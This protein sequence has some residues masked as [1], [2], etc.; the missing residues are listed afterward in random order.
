[1]KQ[2]LSYKIMGSPE[3]D[4]LMFLHGFGTASWGWWQQVEALEE[5]YALLLVDLPGHGES[6]HITWENMEKTVDLVADLIPHGK[7]V[8]LIG[9]SL[10]GHVALELAK[11]YPENIHSTYISG[12]TT[13]P[14]GPKFFKGLLPLYLRQIENLQS[15]ETK[16][17]KLFVQMGMPQEKIAA[18]ISEYQKVSL[19]SV[20]A[21]FN[22]LYSF[23][24]DESYS[25]ISAP[26]M[27]VACEYEERGIQQ[28]LTYA[29]TIIE[30]AETTFIKDARHQWPLQKPAL[31]NQKIKEWLAHVD[32]ANNE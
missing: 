10:G 18:A 12:I 4:M 15:N 24:I 11:K 1:M 2:Q 25:R 28:T 13:K 17:Q 3:K 20:R 5:E 31:F 14:M 21:I 19:A 29:P 7:K 26:L 30:K 9:I 16:L 6:T 27:F 32:S 22:E 23:K 8:H